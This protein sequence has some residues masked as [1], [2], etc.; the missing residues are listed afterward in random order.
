M[1]WQRRR[2]IETEPTSL[3]AYSLLSRL[4]SSQRC[5]LLFCVCLK[6][7]FAQRVWQTCVRKSIWTKEI[8]ISRRKGEG[9]WSSLRTYYVYNTALRE[10]RKKM[11]G[12]VFISVRGFCCFLFK[13]GKNLTLINEVH[14]INE[15]IDRIRKELF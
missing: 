8:E 15:N 3:T 6:K 10:E 14:Q 1:T 7:V 5:E 11:Y 13:E 9:G 2:R 12:S 4:Y